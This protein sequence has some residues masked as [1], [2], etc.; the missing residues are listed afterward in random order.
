M[1]HYLKFGK[2]SVDVILAVFALCILSPLFFVLALLIK[3]D[4]RGSIF[5]LQNRVGL[6]GKCFRIVKFRT[7]RIFEDSYNP[8][9]SEMENNSRVTFCGRYLRRWGLDELPQLI[10]VIR[11]DMSIVGP[12]PTLPYQVAKYSDAQR[13]RLAVRPGL[14]GLAQVM[15]RNSLTWEE[16]IKLDI[17]YVDTMSFS[18]DFIV[19]M[20]TLPV[21]FAPNIHEFTRADRIS[22]HQG[23]VLGNVGAEVKPRN[24]KELN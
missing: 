18:T 7:M 21:L 23:S 22:E 24:D 1:N 19:I 17:D 9:G 20:K 14:T 8:D 10:N 13:K 15:G 16:K 4:S 6:E 2:R 5:F 12:R 3:V 11:G